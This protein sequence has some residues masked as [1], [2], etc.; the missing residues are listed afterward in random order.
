MMN[1]LSRI[2]YSIREKGLIRTYQSLIS[3][4][5][6]YGFDIRNGTDT[7]EIVN[8]EDLDIAEEDKKHSVLYQPTRIRHFNKLLRELRFPEGSVFVDFGSGK[9]RVLLVATNYNFKRVVGVEISSQLCKIARNNLVIYKKKLKRQLCV[10]IVQS[11]VLQYNIHYDENVFYFFRPFDGLIMEKILEKIVNSWKEYP[12]KVWLIINS[13]IYNDLF[14]G[15]Q[16]FQRS[17]DFAHGG[18]EFVVYETH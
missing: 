1:L 17:L 3:I 11:N 16:M 7:S 13:S 12:R 5:E 9:G 14:D 18:I 4:L 15:K 2:L 8:V 6:D 10:E